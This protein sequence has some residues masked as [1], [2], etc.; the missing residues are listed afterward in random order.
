MLGGC[1]RVVETTR[2]DMTISVYGE[3][4]TSDVVLQRLQDPYSG[5]VY[6]SP[7]GAVATF[8]LPDDSVIIVGLDWRRARYRCISEQ[9]R[10]S[11]CDSGKSTGLNKASDGYVFESAA[12]PTSV[13]AFQF[14][15]R[16]ASFGRDGYYEFFSYPAAKQPPIRVPTS[17][18]RIKLV[19]YRESASQDSK[20][21]DTLDR[22]FPGYELTRHGEVIAFDAT[23]LSKAADDIRLPL[24]KQ[25]H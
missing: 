14:E 15:P 9:G 12:A 25:R 20:P 7:F 17:D 22:D 2:I 1:S 3:E 18:L 23:P 24:P 16:D 13:T 6:N 4:Y 10:S 11:S 19:S 8:R 5:K 21:R